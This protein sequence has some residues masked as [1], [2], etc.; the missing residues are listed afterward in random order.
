MLRHKTVLVLGAG[1]SSE[2]GLP[3]GSEL[4][5][6]I[7]SIV[8]CRYDG[9]HL[10][11]GDSV[12]EDALYVAAEKQ[13]GTETAD[14]YIR[15]G[16]HISDAMP[17][18]ISIDNFID[19]HSNDK[20]IVT[21]GKLAICRAILAAEKNSTLYIDHQH[22]N[23]RINFADIESTWFNSFIKLVTENC[24]AAE[25]ANRLSSLTIVA[26]NYDRCIEHFLYHSLQNYYKIPSTRAAALVQG[27]HIYHPYG[28]VGELPWQAASVPVAFGEELQPNE[29]FRVSCEVK[30]FTEGTDP[31]ASE[32]REIRSAIQ[33]AKLLVF[34]GFAF[35]R[36]NVELLM[37]ASAQ[38][39]EPRRGTRVFGT[40]KGLSLPDCD[41]VRDDLQTLLRLDY[42]EVN[43]G[44]DLTAKRLFDEHWRSLSGF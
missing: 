10:I 26:F 20:Q 36:Q 18:A 19:V 12:Y 32:I 11:S 16:R 43:V 25:L 42:G 35:H 44:P 22:P 29:L 38:R 13:D 1:A 37:P 40:G 14:Q 31:D 34:L 33:E 27:I 28:V 39:P 24:P 8:N 17:Q 30:T 5:K 21:C 15:A 2:A 23:A 6:H 41:S 9:S 3:V 7:A 4:T